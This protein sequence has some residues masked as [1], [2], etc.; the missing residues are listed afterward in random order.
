MSREFAE[1]NY[2]SKAHFYFPKDTTAPFGELSFLRPDFF[3]HSGPR[4]PWYTAEML[5]E[6]MAPDI[7]RNAWAQSSWLAQEVG[8]EGQSAFYNTK[9][10]EDRRFNSR[11]EQTVIDARISPAKKAVWFAIRPYGRVDGEGR[12]SEHFLIDGKQVYGFATAQHEMSGNA[13]QR[14]KKRLLHPE[15]DYAVVSDVDVDPKHQGKYIGMVLFYFTH[16]LFRPDQRPVTFVSA[17]NPRL[18]DKL[19]EF[20]YKVTGSKPRTD[21]VP[22]AVIE[23]VRLEAD[24]VREVRGR[25]V[26]H[27]PCLKEAVAMERLTE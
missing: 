14:F 1:P 12:V 20:S 3:P 13:Y 21:L 8:Q 24:S 19:G 23:E 4:N 25:L 9:T 6:S 16:G 10:D 15:E 22:G 2:F 5:L 11:I 7:L 17:T 18:I 26:E 27:L